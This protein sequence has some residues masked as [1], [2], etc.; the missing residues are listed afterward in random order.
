MVVE[1]GLAARFV[2]LD[3]L[4]YRPSDPPPDTDPLA[5]PRSCPRFFNQAYTSLRSVPPWQECSR[6]AL[7]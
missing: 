3:L 2:R 6:G 1:E 7:C 5:D 4:D